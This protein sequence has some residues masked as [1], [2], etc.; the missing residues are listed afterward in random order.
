MRG[1]LN[2]ILGIAGHD[3]TPAELPADDDL[4]GA[5]SMGDETAD[6]R[7]AIEGGEEF[8]EQPP[9]KQ[10]GTKDKHKDEDEKEK[11]E[12]LKRER[13]KAHAD[14]IIAAIG[15][16]K[17]RIDAR[18]A[19]GQLGAIDVLRLRA[20]IVVVAAAG[21]SG[22]SASS[23]ISRTSSQAFPSSGDVS[24]PRLLG[25]ILFIFFGGSKPAIRDLRLEASFNELT[26][27]VQ[28]SW[29]S[30]F[31]TMQVALDAVRRHRENAALIKS[32]E[33]LA[34][35]L[36]AVTQLQEVEL[37]S[38]GIM[39]VIGAMNERYTKRLGFD[40]STIEKAHRAE[41]AKLNAAR[42]VSN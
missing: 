23:N 18:A 37:T 15:S 42:A 33:S 19:A 6:A 13:R 10:H 29:A 40:P 26:A 30:C 3:D 5:F 21:W 17:E 1:F 7:N 34:Q 36:Y 4:T 41:I 27:D 9:P 2:R 39:G 11:I 8:A 16:F 28:E 22:T 24:W 38:P 14:Q 25:R 32:M 31:W 35:R 12:R 20:L